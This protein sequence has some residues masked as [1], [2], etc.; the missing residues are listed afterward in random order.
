MAAFT[1][2]GED[3]SASRCNRMKLHKRPLTAASFVGCAQS[4]P[5]DRNNTMEIKM[6]EIKTIE[7]SRGL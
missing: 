1:A 4:T 7:I 5:P 3:M 6:M 2:C